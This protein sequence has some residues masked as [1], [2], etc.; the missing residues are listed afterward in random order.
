MKSSLTARQS[1]RIELIFRKKI[2]G[3]RLKACAKTIS[4]KNAKIVEID[5]NREFESRLRRN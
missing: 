5:Q 2:G 1:M 3:L 4:S